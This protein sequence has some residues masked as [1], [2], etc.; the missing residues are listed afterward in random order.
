MW[1]FWHYKVINYSGL[2]NAKSMIIASNH[3]SN[4]DPPLIG[5]VTPFEMAYLAKAELFKNKIFGALLRKLNVIPVIRH[6]ADMTA[7]NYSMGILGEGK[8]LLLFPEGTRNGKSIKPGV[9]LFA[10][11]TQKDI[12]PIRVENTDKFWQCLFFLKRA[13]LIIGEPIKKEFFADWSHDKESYQK[14]ADHVYSKIL[15]L[16][17]GGD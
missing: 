17:R 14:L 4:F 16:N 13:R 10:I 12:L 6:S 3:I 9:G 1:L 15:E 2:A 5:A 11:K 7:I 8:S